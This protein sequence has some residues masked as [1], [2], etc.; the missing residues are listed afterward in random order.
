MDSW[1]NRLA[2]GDFD[3]ELAALYGSAREA[4]DAVACCT[5]PPRGIRGFGPRRAQKY[6]ALD[7]EDYL[8]QSDES[9]LR[10]LQIEHVDAVSDLDEIARVE[11]IDL[12]VVGPNDLSASYGLLGRTRDPEMMK[13]YD[14]IADVC[15]KCR[16]PFG[17]SLFLL[18]L[19]RYENETSC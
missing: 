11:G 1:K 9:L 15:K 13:I 10:I 12:L 2:S 8:A 7:I 4:R 5:Y 16:M 19:C 3:G 17:V 14:H 6:G 18:S